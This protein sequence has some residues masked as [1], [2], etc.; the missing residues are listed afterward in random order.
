MTIKSL[1]LKK[2][3]LYSEKNN[4]NFFNNFNYIFF[5]LFVFSFFVLSKEIHAK[6]NEMPV[7]NTTIGPLPYQ[8]LNFSRGVY[9]K[10]A[11]PENC[12]EG[13]Y[14]LLKDPKSGRVFLK[15]EQG[16][17]IDNLD[18]KV[19]NA[20]ERDCVF[21]YFNVI[22]S[23]NELEST[24]VQSC[25]SPIN[26]SNI[27]TLKIKF[28]SESINYVFIAKDPIKNTTKKTNC[29]LKKES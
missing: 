13:E 25:K 12:I 11:G 2:D 10:T 1:Y 6:K 14:R 3:N 5:T 7:V 8:Q 9:K 23:N 29:E 17:L 22:N 4:L 21:S 19:V 15:T 20:G 24:E 16:I 26:V 18:Q 28:D 27:R